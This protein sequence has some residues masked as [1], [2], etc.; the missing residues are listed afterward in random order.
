[1]ID[2][3][4][5]KRFNDTYGHAF[6]D[7]VLREVS[8]AV[9]AQGRNIDTVARYG[10][11]EIAVLLPGA[12]E[13]GK[14]AERIRRAVEKLRFQHETGAVGVTISLGVATAHQTS[15]MEML[16]DLDRG[17]TVEN[18]ALVAQADAKLYQAKEAGRN[19]VVI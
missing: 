15:A 7:L 3:D 4:H 13:P 10:G 9:M 18:V 17:V 6:G 8:K 2:I 11:E 1:M 19:R 14:I 16:M 5:F 12:Q